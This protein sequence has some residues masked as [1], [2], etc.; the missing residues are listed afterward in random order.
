MKERL[1]W[2]KDPLLLKLR[3]NRNSPLDIITG[4]P[5]VGGRGLFCGNLA[6]A[7]YVLEIWLQEEKFQGLSS[8]VGEK[9]TSKKRVVKG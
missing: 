3:E 7:G 6:S 9:I 4:V 1:S 5:F 2:Q 8:P